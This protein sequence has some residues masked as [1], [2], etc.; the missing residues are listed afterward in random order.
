MIE[1][2]T[3]HL[4]DWTPALLLVIDENESVFIIGLKVYHFFC[5]DEKVQIGRLRNDA[6]LKMSTVSTQVPVILLFL[7]W[8]STK[9]EQKSSGSNTFGFLSVKLELNV[10]IS[11]CFSLLISSFQRAISISSDN[12]LF[13]SRR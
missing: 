3:L 9:F 7:T 12:D 13:P 11:S 5:D 8:S 6:P 10:R 4:S 2:L 1:L